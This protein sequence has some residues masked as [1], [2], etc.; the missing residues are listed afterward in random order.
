M[1]IFAAAAPGFNRI[2][3]EG[4]RHISA[5]TLRP[6]A[7]VK[8]KV[9]V[10]ESELNRSALQLAQFYQ[11]QG[12][13]DAAVTWRQDSTTKAKTLVFLVQ[14]G[15]RAQISAVQ[16]T[17]NRTY[18]SSDLTYLL[19][20]RRRDFMIL[21]DLNAALTRL[22]DFYR[23]HGFY[24]A[25]CTLMTVRESGPTK[26]ATTVASIQVDLEFRVTEGPVC[27]F[28]RLQVRGNRQTKR[29][30]IRRYTGIRHGE[31]FSQSQLVTAQHQLYG[32]QLFQRVYLT[33]MPADSADTVTAHV[34]QR[35]TDS[36]DV[37][38]DVAEL[39]PRSFG[40]GVGLQLPPWRGLLS[41]EWEHLNVAGEGHDFR[42]AGDYSPVAGREF[43][44][45]YLAD[46]DL[47]YRIPY[48]TRWA[49]NFS[50]HP[51]GKWTA[52]KQLRQLELGAET[53]MSHDF[54][55]TLTMSLLNNLDQVT[56]YFMVVDT[57]VRAITNLLGASLTWDTRND[58]FNPSSGFYLAPT[59]EVAGGVLGGGNSFYRARLETRFFRRLLFGPILAL[60]AVGGYVLPYGRSNYVPDYEEFYLGGTSS[61]RGYNEKSIGPV[62]DPADSSRYGDVML[63]TNVELRSPFILLHNSVVKG[64]GAVIF[65][66]GGLVRSRTGVSI[67]N[68]YQLAVGAGIRLNTVIG[69]LRLDYGKRLT[70]PPKGDWGRI[71]F[72]I[73]NL[74]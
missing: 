15:A 34:L 47:T 24:F 62:I 65:Q 18:S 23:D 50:T 4:N 51:Y 39:S 71:H 41:A 38:V 35:A 30:L 57:P 48:V 63:N 3:F 58:L 29:T 25:Q 55:P 32:S 13:L 73:L 49:I 59:L 2:K 28:R 67:W 69:P 74:F 43:L 61:V 40:F 46:L 53:G 72:A 16:V 31:R 21:P 20:V 26:A 17:G 14:E 54:S 7:M 11:E 68:R 12:F 19:D 9:L 27:Y 45:D 42:I 44:H 6:V 8:T 1:L 56:R 66:D 64:L 33:V 70:T 60:R 22:L 5:R 10:S 37:R 36:L 52:E